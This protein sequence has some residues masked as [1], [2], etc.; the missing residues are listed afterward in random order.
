MPTSI[1]Y[2]CFCLLMILICLT[3]CSGED[4]IYVGDGDARFLDAPPLGTDGYEIKFPEMVIKTGSLYEYSVEHFPKKGRY[5][6]FL[7]LDLYGVKNKYSYDYFEHFYDLLNFK[8]EI[9]KNS[10]IVK[11]FDSENDDYRVSIGGSKTGLYFN[12]SEYKSREYNELNSSVIKV[13]KLDEHVRLKIK[14][15]DFR[16]YETND[17]P[18]KGNLILKVDGSK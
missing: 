4:G 5:T 3:S 16:D 6:L 18:L 8:I 13:K 10:Q 15:R 14:F 12:P 11:Q 17:Y 7:S 9:Y 1:K 2:Y